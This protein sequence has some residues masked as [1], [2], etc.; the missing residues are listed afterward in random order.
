MSLFSNLLQR[1]LDTSFLYPDTCTREVTL[2]HEDKDHTIEM[3]NEHIGGIQ[4]VVDCFFSKKEHSY[5]SHLKYSS[6]SCCLFLL[7]LLIKRQ[8]DFLSKRTRM[9]L[10]WPQRTECVRSGTPRLLRLE[11]QKKYNTYLASF[12]PGTLILRTQSPCC[13]KACLNRQHGEAQT[14]DLWLN[15]VS[16]ESIPQPLNLPADTF[17][18]RAKNTHHLPCDSSKFLT[19][20]TWV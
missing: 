1:A 16:D 18:T 3:A 6:K 19:P 7:P 10:W 5:I 2:H 9:R 15:K 4:A 12:P 14:P 17:N 11:H 20:T 13:E 8:S